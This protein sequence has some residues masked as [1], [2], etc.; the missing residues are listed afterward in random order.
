[1]YSKTLTISLFS[2][3]L[4]ILQLCFGFSLTLFFLFYPFTG[5]L[6]KSKSDLLLIESVLGQRNTISSIDPEKG[7]L[8]QPKSAIQRSLFESLPENRKLEIQ[9]LHRQ[10]QDSLKKN[11]LAQAADGFWMILGLPKLASLWALIAIVIPIFLLLRNPKALPFAWLFP[12]IALGYGWNNQTHGH[13][14]LQSLFPKES[15]LMDQ[16]DAT[17]E[18]W[19]IAW[20]R[21]LIKEWGKETPS[22]N[23][24]VFKSQ[25]VKGEFFFNL[26]RIEHI[27][28]D[29]S[30]S[31]WEKRS[32]LI[33]IIFLVWNTYFAIHISQNVKGVLDQ[34][35]L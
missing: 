17:R 3:F 6:F 12:L 25:A 2:R 5:K 29:L 21:Y 18:E 14:P 1:M 31:F 20:N 4:I 26:A 35:H 22:L 11:F 13:D 9:N 28:D 8:L 19:E 16:K 32:L 7:A 33:L 15:S 34:S 23:P 24:D 10:I 30:A 27:S